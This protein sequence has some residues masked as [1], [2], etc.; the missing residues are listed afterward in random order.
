MDEIRCRHFEPMFESNVDMF[1]ICHILGFIGEGSN[2]EDIQPIG[3][4]VDNS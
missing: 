3:G 4:R 1:M 2:V